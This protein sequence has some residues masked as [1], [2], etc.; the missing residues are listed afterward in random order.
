MVREFATLEYQL[1]NLV[2][3]TLTRESVLR[4]VDAVAGADDRAA[5]PRPS[6]RTPE[7]L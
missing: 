2:V 3:A 7:A 1:P 4:A 5:G 6:Q